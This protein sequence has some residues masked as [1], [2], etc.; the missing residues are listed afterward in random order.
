MSK[1]TKKLSI[2][3]VN[4]GLYNFKSSKYINHK[5][6]ECEL[7]TTLGAMFGVTITSKKFSECSWEIIIQKISPE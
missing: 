4:D 1:V 6:T 7:L 2:S 5:M 3:R